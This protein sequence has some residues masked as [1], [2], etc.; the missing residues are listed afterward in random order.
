MG[1]V[2][3]QHGFSPK[4][5]MTS[6]SSDISEADARV[7]IVIL[8]TVLIGTVV[9]YIAAQVYISITKTLKQLYETG[10]L[11]AEWAPYAELFKS[12]SQSSSRSFRFQNNSRRATIKETVVAALTEAK[13]LKDGLIANLDPA[14]DRTVAKPSIWNTEN[15]NRK[16]PSMF[17]RQGET[18][19]DDPLEQL[20]YLLA[21]PFRVADK[22]FDVA[23]DVTASYIDLVFFAPVRTTRSVLGYII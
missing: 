10:Q 12:N 1:K 18:K 23:T 21:L 19:I 3:L 8:F 7:S 22:T 15:E 11:S 9:S 14:R 5:L 2:Y 16:R 6:Y 13:E 4:R 17:I 20:P